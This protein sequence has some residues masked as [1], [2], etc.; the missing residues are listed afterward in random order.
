MVMSVKPYIYIFIFLYCFLFFVFYMIGGGIGSTPKGLCKPREPGIC[1][2]SFFF[3]ISLSLP[4]PLT[5][6]TH[7]IHDTI[8][9][10]TSL[11]IY[12]LFAL[13]GRAATAVRAASP[14]L[15]LQNSTH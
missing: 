4:S 9:N 12:F 11:M 2:L 13:S 3:Y 1:L 15:S 14:S 8:L 6:S 5:H 7:Y 10:M